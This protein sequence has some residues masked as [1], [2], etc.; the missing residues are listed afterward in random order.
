MQSTYESKN[1]KEHIQN[2][3][4]GTNVRNNQTVQIQNT[5]HGTN[6]TGSQQK[7]AKQCATH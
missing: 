1:L 6:V 5:A 4:Q 2:S 3:A 7:N